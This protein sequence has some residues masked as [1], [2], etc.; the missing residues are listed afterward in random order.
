MTKFLVPLVLIL[1]VI[2]ALRL[3]GVFDTW[4][5]PPS[6]ALPT[7]T[8]T[9]SR[10]KS[11]QIEE[12]ITTWC[13]KESNPPVDKHFV[14]AEGV[15]AVRDWHDYW[16]S[17]YVIYSP[18]GGKTWEVKPNLF[19]VHFFNETEGLAATSTSVLKTSNGGNTWAVSLS[20]G[21]MP[22]RCFPRIDRLIV[23]DEQHI[24]VYAMNSSNAR[25]DTRDGGQTW[26]YFRCHGRY[27]GSETVC[28]QTQDGGETWEKV[29]IERKYELWCPSG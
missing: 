17:G 16:D 6:T 29:D 13:Q 24:L 3:G 27:Y 8:Q 18:D 25:I 20:L 23:K 19:A 7:P 28:W 14:V 12:G 5:V 11:Q 26:E 21:N 2:L 4:L 22:S 1:G 15:W 9:T 10:T